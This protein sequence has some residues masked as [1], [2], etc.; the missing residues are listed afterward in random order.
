MNSHHNEEHH[1]SR[2]Y[3]DPVC[4]MTTEKEGE[5]IHH[6]HNGTSYYFCSEHCLVKFKTDPDAFTG[7]NEVEPTALA[8]P[9]EG[10]RRCPV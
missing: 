6:K 9:Q 1:H 2:S 3:K 10:D 7:K 4:G 5:F 8:Q